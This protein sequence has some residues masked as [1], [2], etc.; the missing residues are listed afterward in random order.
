MR[1]QWK[2]SQIQSSGGEECLEEPALS[3]LPG[4]GG[5]DGCVE[6][7]EIGR[8][9]VREIAV[10]RMIPDILDWVRVRGVGWEPLDPDEPGVFREPHLDAHGLVRPAPVPEESEPPWEV[11]AESPDERED[12]RGPDLVAVL[13]PVQAE[14]GPPRGHP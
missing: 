14:P 5:D 9:E 10:L 2:T 4:Q 8:G 1:K 11:S 6:V 3:P 13:G 12:I 7:G